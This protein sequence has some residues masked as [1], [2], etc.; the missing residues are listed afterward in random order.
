MRNSKFFVGMVVGALISA[1]SILVAQGPRRP[2]LFAAQQAIEQA[3]QRITD[4]QRANEYD[5]DGH[6]QRAKEFL[7]QARQEIKLATIAANRH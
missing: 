2:N 3:W 1:G 7:G 5:M 6:A 4:A